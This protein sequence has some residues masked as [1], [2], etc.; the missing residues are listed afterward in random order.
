MKM[1]RL[2]LPELVIMF[3]IALFLFGAR[4]FSQE[5]RQFKIEYV[6]VPLFFLILWIRL[7]HLGGLLPF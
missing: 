1:F 7:A 3:L 6:L 4:G 2:G 5:E